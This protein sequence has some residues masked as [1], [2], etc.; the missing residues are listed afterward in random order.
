MMVL[1][2]ILAGH[3]SD[4]PGV[5]FY[6]QRLNAKNEPVVNAHGLPLIDCT[7]GTNR[8]ENVYKHIVTT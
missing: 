8:P 5:E 2:D 7:R 3:A 1:K 6:Q 4:L